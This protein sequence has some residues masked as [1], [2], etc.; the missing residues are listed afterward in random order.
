MWRARLE[1]GDGGFTWHRSYGRWVWLPKFEWE[2]VSWRWSWWWWMLGDVFS[3]IERRLIDFGGG[4]AQH[5]HRFRSGATRAG[6]GTGRILYQHISASHVYTPACFLLKYFNICCFHWSW[7]HPPLTMSRDRMVKCRKE[8]DH[9]V[10]QYITPSTCHSNRQTKEPIFPSECLT[11]ISISRSQS[12]PPQFK[13]LLPDRI[14]I[15][16]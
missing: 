4:F 12:G 6:V 13:C 10:S 15:I 3:W 5:T 9:E 16:I 14:F 2:L 11:F 7:A 8:Q 1:E